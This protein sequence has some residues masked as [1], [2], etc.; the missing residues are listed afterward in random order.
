MSRLLLLTSEFIKIVNCH[1]HL[2][3]DHVDCSNMR[4]GMSN[5]VLAVHICP[6]IRGGESG[7]TTSKAMLSSELSIEKGREHEYLL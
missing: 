2:R 3:C 7:R 5:I 4:V 1:A 6:G